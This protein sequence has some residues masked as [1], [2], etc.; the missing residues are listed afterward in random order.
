M[1][2]LSIEPNLSLYMDHIPPELQ[3]HLSKAQQVGAKASNSNIF[4]TIVFGDQC[5]QTNNMLKA[6]P[7]AVKAIKGDASTNNPRLVMISVSL[8]VTRSYGLPP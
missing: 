8:L 7:L 4:A 2:A 3:Q 6:H 1:F 5:R